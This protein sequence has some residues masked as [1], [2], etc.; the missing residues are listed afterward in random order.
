MIERQTVEE[1][2]SNGVVINSIFQELKA[3]GQF[4]M[5]EIEIE[6]LTKEPEEVPLDKAKLSEVS[7][8]D[9][10]ASFAPEPL[11]TIDTN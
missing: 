11:V 5:P 8:N 10:F 4:K 9:S 2:N 6:N 3:E 7:S 1:Q